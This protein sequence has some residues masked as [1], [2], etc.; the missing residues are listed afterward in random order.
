MSILFASSVGELDFWV[1]AVAAFGGICAAAFAALAVLAA[2]YKDEIRARNLPIKLHPEW[3]P[4]SPYRSAY[5]GP[6]RADADALLTNLKAINPLAGI[7]IQSH[8]KYEPMVCLRIALINVGP[9]DA[10][11]VSVHMYGLE[12]RRPGGGWCEQD[13]FVPIRLRFSHGREN[14]IPLMTRGTTHMVDLGVWRPRWENPQLLKQG[15]SP[16]WFGPYVQLQNEV[17]HKGSMIKFGEYRFELILAGEGGTFYK[18]VW[19][20]KYLE[21]LDSDSIPLFE[22]WEEKVF[23][24]RQ[25]APPIGLIPW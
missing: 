2:L 11:S 22:V 16:Q 5:L 13:N 1:S 17:L 12:K 21:I 20:L 4:K 6:E 14:E 9:V 8:I 24:D 15:E 25:K 19:H 10:K 3:H 18:G 23:Q 7:K